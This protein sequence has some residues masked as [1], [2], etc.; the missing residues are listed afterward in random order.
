[1]G[2]A[3]ISAAAMTVSREMLTRF[4]TLSGYPITLENAPQVIAYFSRLRRWR[5]VA[6]ILA[7]PV[8]GFS[9]DPFYLVAGWCTGP[10]LAARRA[11]FFDMAVPRAL[12]LTSV[13]AAALA[14]VHLVLS[15]DPGRTLLPHA[16]VVVAVATAVTLADRRPRMEDQDQ[17]ARALGAW[18]ARNVH[19]A[20]SAVVLASVLLVPGRPPWDE[21][22]G[23]SGPA[24]VTAI[25]ATFETVDEYDAP[26]CPWFDETVAPCR[27]WGSTASRSRRRLPMS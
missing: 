23:H 11:P 20:G 2:A 21:P 7:V 17:A 10:L 22:P 19:L 15:D 18:S 3:A 12:W 4:A 13:T 8:A 1:M 25:P 5:L 26:T 9:G 27:F 6:V 16:A 24:E 14:G